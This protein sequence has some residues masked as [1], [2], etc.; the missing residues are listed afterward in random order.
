[1]IR[2]LVPLLLLVG[3]SVA[4]APIAI[5][6]FPSCPPRVAVPGPLLAHESL[7]VLEVRVELAREAERARG[8]ACAAASLARD[9]WI[10]NSTK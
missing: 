4:P 7:S 2:G 1:M 8:D 3:C 6:T 9:N 10:R 5:P